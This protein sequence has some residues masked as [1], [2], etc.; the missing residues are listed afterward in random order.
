MKS[1][2]VLGYLAPEVV[3]PATSILATV[4]GVVLTLGKNSLRGIARGGL[5]RLWSPPK[6]DSPDFR[7]PSMKET[8]PKRMGRPRR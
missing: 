5:Q 2:L 8:S 7:G 6:A 4:V 1:F 3:L